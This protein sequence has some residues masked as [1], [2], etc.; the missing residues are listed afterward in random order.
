MG[1]AAERV[2]AGAV[3]RRRG[4]T[5]RRV[6]PL[7][8]GARRRA[9]RP[10]SSRPAAA[11]RRAGRAAARSRRWQG[12]A[13]HVPVQR[14]LEPPRQPGDGGAVGLRHRRPAAVRA[15]RRAHGGGA[16]RCSGSPRRSR[17]RARGRDARPPVVLTA[18]IAEEAAL[19]AGAL[20]RE[21]FEAGVE[22]ALRTKSTPTDLVSEADLAAEAAIRDVLSA[23]RPD[24]AVLGRGGRPAAATEDGLLW[25][26]D[27]LDGTANFLHGLPAWCVSVA[28][29]DARRRAGGRGARSA[30]RRAVLRRPRTGA[31]GSATRCSAARPARSSRRP[32]S[33]RASR[34]TRGSAAARA[35]WS[36]GCSRGSRNLR[37]VG[38]C[39][40][41][42]AWTA[43]GRL[44]AFYERA[45]QEWDVAAGELLCAE[46]GLV[47]ERLPAVDG[48]P[49]G[50]L[51]APA[52][53]R[54]RPPRH[55]RLGLAR[56][57]PHDGARQHLHDAARA[58]ASTAGRT[59]RRLPRRSAS[60][61]RRGDLL[62][63]R[64]E[65][66][67]LHP[68]G[69]LRRDEAGRTTSTRTPVAS[70]MP[71]ARKSAADLP[72]A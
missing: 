62:G 21:R 42:L 69:H 29:R 68:R 58:P 52:G 51:A 50:I 54:G 36:R 32:S 70:A 16:R 37:R 48:M 12:N 56:Q 61:G 60:D 46:A 53:A 59:P 64:G 38:A 35:R 47:V 1:R 15:D 63:R 20:L 28:V 30:A 65:R 7:F 57:P 67:R 39:A 5:P 23:R 49:A 17:R 71:R 41:D 3:A 13:A 11:G 43:A 6:A 19:A 9:R 24:D 18:T 40:L 27:P 34:T 31:R 45:V 2:L 4:A 8:D 33:G 72:A 55:R 44:D 26:V 25:V 10:R 14:A 22:R 66:R